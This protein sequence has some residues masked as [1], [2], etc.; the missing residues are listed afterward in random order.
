MKYALLIYSDSNALHSAPEEAVRE[1]YAA[2]GKFNDEL[3]AAG[4]TGP[5]GELVAPDTAK[6]VRV[7]DG[8]RLVTDGPFAEMRE[9]LGGF[10][11]IEAAD[12]DEALEWA[13]KIPSASFGTVE[14]RPLAP[15]MR[16]QAG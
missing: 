3:E 12:M 4:K 1:M 8:Q 14:V 16:P 10:Y 11:V 2:F 7:R 9:Q 5:A 15:D 6:S 13:A